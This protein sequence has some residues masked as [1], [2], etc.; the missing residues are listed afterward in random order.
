MSVTYVADVWLGDF[1]SFFTHERAS[2]MEALADALDLC[3]CRTAWDA[4][5]RLGITPT[6]TCDQWWN[7]PV[8]AFNILRLVDGVIEDRDIESCYGK[9]K[10]RAA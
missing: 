4:F 5:M 7:L 2:A 9:Y 10:R 6:G 8:T 1:D 3:G